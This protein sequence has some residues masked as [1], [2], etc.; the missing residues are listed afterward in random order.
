MGNILC[1]VL[2]IVGLLVWLW[3]GA[4]PPPGPMSR[5]CDAWVL[6]DLETAGREFQQATQ[7]KE[8]RVNAW[9]NMGYLALW[10][11]RLDTAEVL[12]QRALE[13]DGDFA[14]AHLELGKLAWQEGKVITADEHFQKAV[15]IPYAPFRA[16]Q[17]LGESRL[18]FRDTSG[19]R[20]A[21]DKALDSHPGYHRTLT[22]L[23][24]LA[25]A[26][27]DT[28][29]ALQYLDTAC[30]E[31]PA[32]SVFQEYLGVLK[33]LGY[34]DRADSVRREYN[35]WYPKHPG[36][37]G[38]DLG[39]EEALFPVGERIRIKFGWEFIT[40]GSADLTVMEWD[41]LRGIPLLHVHASVRSAPLF[42]LLDIEDEY[43]AWI[44]PATG[45]CH[46]FYF[47]MNSYGVDLIGQW[48]YRYAD[49][50]YVSRTVV[51][52]G[53]I[54]GIR[55]RLPAQVTDGLSLVYYF[56]YHAM[57]GLDKRYLFVLD[58]EYKSGELVPEGSVRMFDIHG[59][60]WEGYRFLGVLNCKG[61]AG[62]SG[63]FQ[64][65]FSRDPAPHLIRA[66][67]KIF[68]GSVRAQVEEISS[69]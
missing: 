68:V 10:E 58:D 51:D 61:I 39:M 26:T 18:V 69:P 2:I 64:A 52:D 57:H 28:D 44:D 46:R 13:Y 27:S 9:Y 67:A 11:G 22:S 20:E 19:A 6:G 36:Q 53:Y 48:D 66:E 16:W 35:G 33:A 65:W 41:R 15:H 43:D 42:F 5:G 55:Q 21:F 63:R 34:A 30:R 12:F 23:A 40:F 54:F 49:G 3:A 8:T 29:L 7:D 24:R 38:G 45:I 47:H 62:L 37:E 1:K 32:P 4:Y 60:Q 31:S 50:L 56:R 25:M 17:L 14:P 59:E